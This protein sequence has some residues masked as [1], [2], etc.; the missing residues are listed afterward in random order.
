MKKAKRGFTL[1][2]LI[3][4]IA[5]LAIL[6]A[7]LVPNLLGYRSKAEKS[8]IQSSAKTLLQTIEAYNADKTKASD[9]IGDNSTN[10]S[11]TAG[12]TSL[13]S[14]GLITYS[15]IPVAINGTGAV[16]TV[17]DLSKVADGNFN[18]DSVNGQDST[19]T[20]SS[21]PSNATNSSN[22]T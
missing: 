20:L 6:G 21:K 14:E 11:Y 22:G 1:I 18:V 2:E 3:V 5:V 10:K 9:E 17:A 13:D 4:V 7:I 15:K 16:K 19:I 8:N 12:L